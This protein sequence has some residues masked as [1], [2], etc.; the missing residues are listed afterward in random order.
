VDLADKGNKMDNEV[1]LTDESQSEEAP[2]KELNSSLSGLLD[3]P[4]CGW[5]P[6]SRPE[7]PNDSDTWW[8]VEC[9][10]PYCEVRPLV[11][12]ESPPEAGVAWNTR[13]N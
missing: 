9:K 13:A 8:I 7:T 2:Q 3:C 5:Q 11:M 10:N 1:G 4:F 12:K 6:G